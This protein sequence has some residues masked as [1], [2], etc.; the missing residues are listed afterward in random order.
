M[1]PKFDTGQGRWKSLS[2]LSYETK[3]G[4]GEY[5]LTSLLTSCFTS[6]RTY[7]EKWPCQIRTEFE[8][9]LK[10]FSNLLIKKIRG[11]LRPVL[12][13]ISTF[14]NIQNSMMAKSL[15]RDTIAVKIRIF[16]H[17]SHKMHLK[18]RTETF[19]QNLSLTDLSLWKAD[20]LNAQWEYKAHMLMRQNV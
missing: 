15:M 10:C 12:D 1:F 8:Q 19:W 3:R 2:N 18:Y 20:Y 7:C 11:L 6:I 13:N 9:H 5:F 17:A 14:K 16:K 4:I